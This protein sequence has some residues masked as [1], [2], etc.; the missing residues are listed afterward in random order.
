MLSGTH[1]HRH[2]R[3]IKHAAR[4]VAYVVVCSSCDS[5]TYWTSEKPR[6]NVFPPPRSIWICRHPS[7]SPLYLI[8]SIYFCVFAG[9][10]V[11]KMYIC[12]T[13]DGHNGSSSPIKYPGDSWNVHPSRSSSS[14]PRW[15]VL[16]TPDNDYP[17][18]HQCPQKKQESSRDKSARFAPPRQM[19]HTHVLKWFHMVRLGGDLWQDEEKQDDRVSIFCWRLIDAR[20]TYAPH[21]GGCFLS[22]P[23]QSAVFN[24]LK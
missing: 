2:T 13:R 11:V 14:P 7:S 20:N 18:W 15:T 17:T 9:M 21:I 19:Q 3:T 16:R 6:K 23:S 22:P 5:L 4:H 1:T 24:I 10:L 8:H 12:S